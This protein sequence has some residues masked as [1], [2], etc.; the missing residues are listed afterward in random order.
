M[1]QRLLRVKGS[2]LGTT[3]PDSVVPNFTPILNTTFPS[4]QLNYLTYLLNSHLAP[5]FLIG[6]SQDVHDRVDVVIP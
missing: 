4:V 2:A 5:Q 3:E 1:R 6:F